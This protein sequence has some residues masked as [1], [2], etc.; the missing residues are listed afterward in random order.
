MGIYVMD[1]HGD[2]VRRLTD[3]PGWDSLPTWSPDG[4][5]IAFKSGRDSDSGRSD[6]YVMDADGGNVQQLTDDPGWDEYP[7]WS[8]A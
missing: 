5:R 7:A 2:N 1:A 4:T 3:D 6:I 8:P